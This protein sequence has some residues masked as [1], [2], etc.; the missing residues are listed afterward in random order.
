MSD[1]AKLGTFLII[2]IQNRFNIKK[3]KTREYFLFRFLVFSP[4]NDNIWFNVIIIQAPHSIIIIMLYKSQCIYI[5]WYNKYKRKKEIKKIICC[6]AVI[7][8]LGSLLILHIFF[9]FYVCDT[10]NINLHSN[11]SFFFFF[12]YDKFFLLVL[13][14]IISIYH[15]IIYY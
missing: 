6:S 1:D 9:F 8:F 7:G 2:F 5:E 13:F 11:N 10:I 4:Y 14:F 12:A 15:S 3:K